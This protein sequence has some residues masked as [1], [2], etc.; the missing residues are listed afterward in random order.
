MQTPMFPDVNK[1]TGN[2][3]SIMKKR[4]RTIISKY[5]MSQCIHIFS[6]IK[7]DAYAF[8]ANHMAMWLARNM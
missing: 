7:E 8:Q 3:V 1:I 2:L 5:C 4:Q 6:K